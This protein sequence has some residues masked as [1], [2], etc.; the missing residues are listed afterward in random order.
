VQQALPLIFLQFSTRARA[1]KVRGKPPGWQKGRS[2]TPK[3]RF[4]VVKKQPAAA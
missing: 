4:Q 2:R 1:P 3:T